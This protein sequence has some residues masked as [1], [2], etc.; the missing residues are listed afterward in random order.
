[1][2]K[3]EL[4]CIIVED[5]PLAA[6]ILKDY[7]AELQSLNLIAHCT[8]A[9][10]AFDILKSNEI[11][12]IFLDINLP[13][14]KGFDFLQ[15]LQMRPE[16]IITSAF[17]EYALKGFEYNVA[18]YLLKPIEFSRFLNAVNK[19]VNKSLSSPTPQLTYQPVLERK[20]LFFNVGKKNIRVFLDEISYVESVREYVKIYYSN[21]FLLT[22]VKISDIEQALLS[23]NFIRIHRSYIVN[24]I[25]I[26]SF[27]QLEIEINRTLLPVSRSYKEK[28]QSTLNTIK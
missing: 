12:L 7:I 16:I 22:K 15:T 21:K 26:D 19:V 2:R 11:D 24:I 14:L 6:E 13:K 8:D 9:I 18:D 20:Y 23:Q 1:M 17:H 3:T 27:S 5:E 4:N 10:A 25:K 28:L